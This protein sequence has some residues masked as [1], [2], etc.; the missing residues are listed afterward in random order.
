VISL[1]LCSGKWYKKKKPGLQLKILEL[2]SSHKKLSKS[3][4]RQILK[5]QHHWPEISNAFDELKNGSF[6]EI[7]VKDRGKRGKPQIYYRLTD[8]GMAVLI[9]ENHSPDRFWSLMM[10]YCY[11]R[12]EN[13]QVSMQTI[14]DFYE[15][16]SKRIFKFSSGHNSIIILDTINDVCN[17]WLNRSRLLIAGEINERTTIDNTR[18][19]AGHLVKV[20]ELLVYSPDLTIDELSSRSGIPSDALQAAMMMMIMPPNGK[21]VTTKIPLN[22]HY[23]SKLKQ[24]FLEHCFIVSRETQQGEKFK[25]SL[26]GIVLFL[27]YVHQKYRD[28]SSLIKTLAEY[29]DEIALNYGYLLPLIFGKWSSQKR[30]LKSTA[31][32]NFSIILDKERRY[33]GFSTSVVLEGLNE[34]YE[35]MKN[36][37]RSNSL[38]IKEIYNAGYD[39]FKEILSRRQTEQRKNKLKSSKTKTNSND[40]TKVEPVAHKFYEI[41]QLMRFKDPQSYVSELF[42]EQQ[43]VSPIEIY[44][45]CTQDEMTFVYY[46]NLLK[47]GHGMDLS[48]LAE[49]LKNPERLD[50]PHEILTKILEEDDEIDLWFSNWMK[51]I[52]Q[53]ESETFEIIKNY[54]ETK[55]FVFKEDDEEEAKSWI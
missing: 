18:V 19:Q 29:Y 28:S 47:K 41:W 34:Y 25:L 38:T 31:M 44:S 3:D 53:Y 37:I 32:D 6:I 35:N 23:L 27:T 24:Q 33:S 40:T 2:L 52:R 4:A 49:W 17:D 21:F 9:L 13:E 45:T 1:Y 50:N 8:D 15:F 20:L 11:S 36:I 39:A 16:F 43:K 10:H 7:I 51:D 46:L 14:D 22:G 48:F 55:H 30:R 26:F 12:G 5:D 42:K 54:E